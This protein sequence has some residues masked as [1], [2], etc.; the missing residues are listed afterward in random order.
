V[1][2]FLS[3]TPLRK[4]KFDFFG[5]ASL[6]VAI[7]AL[8]LMLDRGQTEDWFSSPQICI[9]AVLTGVGFY[10]FA[11]HV[12]TTRAK[13]FVNPALFKDR[14]FAAGTAFIF[15]IGIVMF[16]T[17]ALLPPLLQDLMNYPVILTGWLTAPRGIGSLIAMFA[18]GRLVRVV[19]SRIILVAGFLI[20]AYSLYLMTS[21][22]LQMDVPTVLWSGILQGL[23]TG[24]VYV[25]LASAAF[26]T[27]PAAQRDEGTTLF[28]LI[29][30]LGSSAG[31]SAVT[32]LLVRN[33]QEMHS[34]LGENVTPFVNPWHP[35]IAATQHDM[36]LLN[37]SI[38][39]QASM[40]AYNNNFKLMMLLA[41]GAIPLA[42]L[43]RKP[44]PKQGA[45]VEPVVVE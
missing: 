24:L 43:L 27:L 32:T 42:F 1:L 9:C 35:G 28:S 45:A 40:I 44:Q 30:N 8:Q 6:S 11:V 31:I 19:D 20:S 21:F 15:V 4:S 18:V 5:F 12:M 38:T 25:P 13:P 7:G 23:G 22:Y 17:L 2:S 14:N 16:A 34:R 10:L 33:T 37:Y 39:T 3:E 41:L 29:R 36:A 26:G